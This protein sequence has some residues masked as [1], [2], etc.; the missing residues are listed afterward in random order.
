VT[1]LADDVTTF[2]CHLVDAL[3]KQHGVR[4]RNH[5]IEVPAL[6]RAARDSLEHLRETPPA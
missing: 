3:L 4:V 6:L 5:T 2:V 1:A